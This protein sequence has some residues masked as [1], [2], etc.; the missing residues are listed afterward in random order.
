MISDNTKIGTGLLITVSFYRTPHIMLYFFL[1]LTVSSPG[2]SS[3]HLKGVP[4]PSSWGN[5]FIRFCFTG[6]WGHSF[7]F[8]VDNDDWG[9]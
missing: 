5:I 3:N 8:G 6:T 7:S 4:F 1:Y 9:F 2:S